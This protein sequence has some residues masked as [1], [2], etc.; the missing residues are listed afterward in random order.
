M[1]P[2]FRRHP[3]DSPGVSSFL[4]FADDEGS[5]SEDEETADVS[6]RETTLQYASAQPSPMHRCV[7]TLSYSMVVLFKFRSYDGL[8]VE[9]IKPNTCIE[10]L[11][12]ITE[13]SQCIIQR[14]E[15]KDC[16]TQYGIVRRSGDEENN[17]SMR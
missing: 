17:K 16:S 2:L 5:S 15:R 8:V 9:F 13:R 6:T 1:S 4:I 3:L 7:P 11:S 12:Q 14:R 10:P